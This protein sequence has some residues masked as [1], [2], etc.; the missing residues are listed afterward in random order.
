MHLKLWEFIR[1][2]QDRQA[3]TGFYNPLNISSSSVSERPHRSSPVPHDI[4]S[5]PL[6]SSP[7]L[8]NLFEEPEQ[9]SEEEKRFQRRWENGFDIKTDKRYNLWSEFNGKI[10]SNSPSDH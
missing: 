6:S 5:Q 7:S 4:Y 1:L 10:S 9:F 8:E 2:I 3:F